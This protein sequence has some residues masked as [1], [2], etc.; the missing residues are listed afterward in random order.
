MNQLVLLT[1]STM[2]VEYCHTYKFSYQGSL[3]IRMHD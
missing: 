3:R 1:Y 2:L